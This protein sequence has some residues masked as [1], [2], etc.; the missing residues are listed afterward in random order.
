MTFFKKS[1]TGQ[2]V[3]EGIA[4]TISIKLKDPVFESQTKIN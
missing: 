1:F 2:D 4:G 3:R